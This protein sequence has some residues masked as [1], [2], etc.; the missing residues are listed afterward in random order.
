M[1]DELEAELR[2]KMVKRAD[3]SSR[4]VIDLALG[5]AMREVRRHLN[6][7]CLNALTLLNNENLLHPEARS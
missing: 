3:G 7:R 5:R 2:E 4:L 6:S 1:L